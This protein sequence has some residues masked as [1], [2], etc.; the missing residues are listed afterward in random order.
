MYQWQFS[1]SEELIQQRQKIVSLITKGIYAMIPI[2]F[3]LIWFI[4][5]AYDTP[6]MPVM[7][8]VIHF[9]GL[10]IWN[11]KAKKSLGLEP[12]VYTID[13]LGLRVQSL[14]SNKNKQYSWSKFDFFTFNTEHFKE[15]NSME[16][17]PGRYV[18]LRTR[19]NVLGFEAIYLSDNMDEVRNA[20]SK[21]IPEK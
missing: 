20:L 10:V 18:F 21:Y 3:G 12:E 6:L 1:P 14:S 19:D 4:D 9:V 13:D 15:I 11:T 7:L 5:G 17:V 16:Y 2:S 8:L